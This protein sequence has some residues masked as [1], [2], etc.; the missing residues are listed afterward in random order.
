MLL[1]LLKYSL[2]SESMCRASS[3]FDTFDAGAG[4]SLFGTSFS[5]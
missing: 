5:A 2:R 3:A 1:A 4:L